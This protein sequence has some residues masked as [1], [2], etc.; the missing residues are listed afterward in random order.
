MATEFICKVGRAG[1]PSRD[2]KQLSLWSMACASDLTAATTQV[3]SSTRHTGTKFSVQDG[4]LVYL[5]RGGS[6]M[7]CR[8]W[9]LHA[10]ATQTLVR[11]IRGSITPQAGDIWRESTDPRY[12]YV[13]IQDA[14]DSVIAVAECYNDAT[15]VDLPR[16][17][18]WTTNSVNRL[19]IYTP[20]SE[21]HEVVAGTGFALFGY[22]IDTLL[23]LINV[24]IL[25]QGI[26]FR[27]GGRQIGGNYTLG[28]HTI[29]IESC[30]FHDNLCWWP[31]VDIPSNA[32]LTTKICLLYTSPSPRDRTRS[33][34]PSSA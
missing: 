15:M 28:I 27:G 30:I 3:F 19:K 24:D 10:T 11:D 31:M 1:F 6:L 32:Y 18:G 12:G 2:Y 9:L 20:A 14:G 22:G 23:E 29:E 33:R 4:R 5:Y 13:T 17:I 26:E 25:I 8:A 7:D 16:L 21:R 34:M